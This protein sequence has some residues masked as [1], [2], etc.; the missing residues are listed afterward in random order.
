MGTQEVGEG[1]Q[2]VG[3]AQEVGGTGSRGAQEGS[4]WCKHEHTLGHSL[5]NAGSSNVF[6]C[7]HVCSLR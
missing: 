7:G 3:G 6:E 4:A 2:E 1:V 5:G